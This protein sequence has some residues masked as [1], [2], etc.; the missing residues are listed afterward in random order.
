MRDRKTVLSILAQRAE[1]MPISEW[2]NSTAVFFDRQQNVNHQNSHLPM[3]EGWTQTT[4]K[5][6]R[7]HIQ[8]TDTARNKGPLPLVLEPVGTP[9]FESLARNSVSKPITLRLHLGGV[10][11]GNYHRCII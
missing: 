6:A 4:N 7:D 5:N 2:C 10:P 3:R 9:H 8:K 1:I 11:A